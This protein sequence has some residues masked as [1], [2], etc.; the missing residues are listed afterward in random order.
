M[1]AEST[2]I[3]VVEQETPTL[4]AP[5]EEDR[6]ETDPTGWIGLERPLSRDEW[7]KSVMQLRPKGAK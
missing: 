3:T 1:F 6:W 7:Y 5:P 2:Q 4:I